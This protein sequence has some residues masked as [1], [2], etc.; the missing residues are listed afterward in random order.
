MLVYVGRA[1]GNFVNSRGGGSNHVCL[2]NLP[3][4]DELPV[5]PGEQSGLHNQITGGEYLTGSGPNLQHLTNQDVPCALCY[6]PERGSMVMI[7]AKVNCPELWTREYYGYL[8]STRT[9]DLARTSYEC[10]DIH[11]VA[12]ESGLPGYTFGAR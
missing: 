9:S 4:L 11:S 1:A 2:P 8:M 10:I 12:V 7:P 3:E 6:T 5:I